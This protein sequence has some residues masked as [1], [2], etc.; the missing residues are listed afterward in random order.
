MLRGW[1]RERPVALQARSASGSWRGRNNRRL[2]LLAAAFSR[3]CHRLIK[4]EGPKL[5]AGLHQLR[6]IKG[7]LRRQF[8]PRRRHLTLQAF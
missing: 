5:A 2:R 6:L 8:L 4:C 3:L 7:P 1:N